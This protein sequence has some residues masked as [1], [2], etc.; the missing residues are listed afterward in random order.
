M[1]NMG[2]LFRGLVAALFV[3]LGVYGTSLVQ[4]T[5]AHAD[6]GHKIICAN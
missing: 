4:A 2:S 6:C 5:V 3:V 1:L